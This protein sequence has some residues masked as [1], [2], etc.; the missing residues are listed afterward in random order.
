MKTFVFSIEGMHCEGCVDTV[1]ALLGMEAGVK[2]AD[3][4]LAD[5]T[6]RVLV[7]PNKVEAK[8]LAAA[9]ERAGYRATLRPQ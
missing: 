7:D 4:S 1:K 8:R 5:G 3:V 2:A 6:A 9:V